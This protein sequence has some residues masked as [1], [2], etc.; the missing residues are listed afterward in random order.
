MDP[1]DNSLP[2]LSVRPESKNPDK[3]PPDRYIR[4]IE[5]IRD[6]AIK[7]KLVN[8]LL[9]SFGGVVIATFTIFFFHGFKLGGFILPESLLRWL[10]VATIGE[11]GGLA[12]LV[13]G[14]FFRG[15][16]KTPKDK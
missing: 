15:K 1:N 6:M 7:G 8:F 14:A 5:R 11:I 12:S 4:S 9:F 13:Y 10:G 2:P 3:V 16:G